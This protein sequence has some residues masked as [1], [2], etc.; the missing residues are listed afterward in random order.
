MGA[1]YNCYCSDITC[2]YPMNGKFSPDQKTIYEGVLRAVTAVEAC[3]KPGISWPDMHQ[4]A[5]EEITKTLIQLGV[6]KGDVKA[7]VAS[8]LAARFMPCGLGHFIGLDTHDVGGYLEGNPERSTEFGFRS[9]RTARTLEENM[10]LT[11]EPGIYFIESQVEEVLA[12]EDWAQFVDDRQ[13]MEQL[14]SFGGVRIE[15]VVIITKDG[16]DNLSQV[17]RTVEE[18]EAVMAGGAWPP[19][20]DKAP[21]LRRT[22]TDWS[23]RKSEF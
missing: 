6:L 3:L 2:S 19:T 22:F 12:S 7:I 16:F 21:E 20:E 5:L 13:R 10:V 11:V 8:G 18:V 15:D 1:E 23:K 9:L 17:P 14:K 4:L